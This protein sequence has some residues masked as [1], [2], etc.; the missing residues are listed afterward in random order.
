MIA[1]R[2]IQ[3]QKTIMK[4][5]HMLYSKNRILCIKCCNISIAETG[6]AE[7]INCNIDTRLLFRKNIQCANV[8]ISVDQ[9]NLFRR[10]SNKGNQKLQGIVDLSI[11]KNL[12]FGFCMITNILEYPV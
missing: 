3:N 4:G 8:H 11:E 12:L 6:V 5:S 9:N 10:L 1:N 7:C 2:I